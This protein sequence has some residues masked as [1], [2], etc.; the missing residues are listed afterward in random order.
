MEQ[1]IRDIEY[2]NRVGVYL[3]RFSWVKPNQVAKCRCPICGDSAKSKL[4]TRGFF[5]ERNGSFW[6]YCHNCQASMPFF[7]FL[8]DYFPA[9]FSEYNFD[10]FRKK[11]N[12]QLY[13]INQNIPDK[14]K[15]SP[16]F[17]S[18]DFLEKYAIK[19]CDLPNDHLG[20]KYIEA[21]KI[22]LED[23]WY[24]EDFRT[25]S[26]Q[27]NSEYNNY[28]IPNTPR[29]VIPFRDFNG[30]L[31]AFQGRALKDKE[32]RYISIKSNDNQPLI[33]GLNK[34]DMDKPII[35]VEGPL[36][37]KLLPNSLAMAGSALN[38]VDQYF[39]PEQ[40]SKM[41]FVWD[42]E[43]KNK[44]N[45]KMMEK[46][47]KAGK[48]VCVWNRKTPKDINAMVL[49]GMTIPQILTL[50]KESTTTGLE[51]SLKLMRYKGSI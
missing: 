31:I 43:P 28:K 7:V 21:R 30:K 18:T 50:I 41:I 4:K 47:I 14:I 36:D 20:R 3:E 51:G 29:I 12:K 44:A 48:K 34:V 23:L 13:T 6:Y 15:S 5:I 1:L 46:F 17:C 16:S 24:V 19:L 49:S 38:K 9:L 27:F 39:T 37:S 32:L 33:F 8:K 26:I 22:P 42:N 11:N 10:R 45:I 25:L 2:V 40:I 35:V